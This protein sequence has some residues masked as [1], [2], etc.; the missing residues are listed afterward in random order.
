VRVSR[1]PQQPVSSRC[2]L[3][4]SG[5][6]ALPTRVPRMTRRARPGSADDGGAVGIGAAAGA[7]KNTPRCV[8][9]RRR[10]R[11]RARAEV[12][13]PQGGWLVR[14]HEPPRGSLA[15]SLPAAHTRPAGMSEKFLAS[16]YFTPGQ[17]APCPLG[18]FPAHSPCPCSSASLSSSQRR[19][20]GSVGQGEVGR[21]RKEC[22]RGKGMG[23]ASTQSRDG[24]RHRAAPSLVLARVGPRL[25][26]RPSR[27]RP[28]K[29]RGRKR[30]FSLKKKCV[31]IP[32]SL[33][34]PFSRA[35]RRPCPP[36]TPPHTHSPSWQ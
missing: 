25:A 17:V 2:R 31:A 23:K 10:R 35:T 32:T 30:T 11:R 27:G 6:L 21:R 4:P 1:S 9:V 22:V 24:A 14:L 33:P 16:T 19:W 3:P 34:I 18:P 28:A 12:A 26:C 5:W 7:L 29:G 13:R 20:G 36:P 8:P 15:R